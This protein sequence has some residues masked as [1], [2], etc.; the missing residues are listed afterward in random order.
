MRTID[1]K[2]EEAIASRNELVYIL[3]SYGI[4]NSHV[5]DQFIKEAIMN[6]EIEDMPNSTREEKIQKLFH[7]IKMALRSVILKYKTG[8]EKSHVDDAIKEKIYQ[9]INDAKDNLIFDNPE[10][11]DILTDYG[12]GLIDSPK[13]DPRTD[14]GKGIYYKSVDGREHASMEAVEQANNAYWDSMMIYPSPIDKI[15]YN[16]IE[17]AYFDIITPKINLNDIN[18]EAEMLRERTEKMAAHIGTRY[19][20]YLEQ[21]LEK[22]GYGRQDNSRGPKR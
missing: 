7:N 5:Q 16:E 3:K 11:K 15:K 20:N 14:F 22:H 6:F 13:I 19:G 21:L 17:K 4:Y 9:Q 12:R 10:H 8:K 18:A 1:L 2:K